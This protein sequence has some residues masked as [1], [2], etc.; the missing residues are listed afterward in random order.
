[1]N[2]IVMNTLTGAVTEYTNFSFQ[3]LTPTNA[4]SAAGLFL[5]GGDVDSATQIDAN[6]TMGKTLQGTTLKKYIDMVYFAMKGAGNVTL[7]VA[8]ENNAYSYSFP[9][10]SSGESRCKPGR[11]L[12]ENYYAF[13]LSNQ[14]GGDFEIDRVEVLVGESTSRRS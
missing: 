5:F 6:F 12:R 7:T 2:A 1:M 10:L 13:G 4:G 3:S 9:V 8:G 14:L 11:G